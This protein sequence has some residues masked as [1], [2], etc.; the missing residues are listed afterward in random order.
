MYA[1]I[2]VYVLHKIMLYTIRRHM[3]SCILAS[4]SCPADAA[5]AGTLQPWFSSASTVLCVYIYIYIYI[6]ICICVICMYVCMYVYIYICIMCRYTYILIYIYIYNQSAVATCMALRPVHLG[7]NLLSPA[8]RPGHHPSNNDDNNNS[9]NNSNT[10]RHTNTLVV[11]IA[12]IGRKR[13]RQPRVPK[14]PNHR[15]PDG[16]KTNIVFIEAP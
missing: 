12:I 2:L 6:R 8:S 9:S 13:P 4:A 5:T 16:V 3:I 10:N 14:V 15:L 7:G 1:T 11:T